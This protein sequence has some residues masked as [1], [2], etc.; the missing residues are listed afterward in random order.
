MVPPHGHTPTKMRG[1]IHQRVVCVWLWTNLFIFPLWLFLWCTTFGAN[2][3]C[4]SFR[5]LMCNSYWFCASIIICKFIVIRDLQYFF[6]LISNLLCQ[7]HYYVSI[8]LWCCLLSRIAFLTLNQK[9]VSLSYILYM[10]LVI[11]IFSYFNYLTFQKSLFSFPNSRITVCCLSEYSRKYSFK[12]QSD[13][14]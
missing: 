6:R 9:P 7:T 3:G 11:L 12:D 13:I 10:P 8:P 2:L 4:S 14:Y 1:T 5:L